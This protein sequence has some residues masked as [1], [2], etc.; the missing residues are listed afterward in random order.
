MEKV[1]EKTATRVNNSEA[2]RRRLEK[3]KKKKAEL[4]ARLRGRQRLRDTGV[5]WRLGD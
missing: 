2:L 1:K 3:E 4:M 5:Y